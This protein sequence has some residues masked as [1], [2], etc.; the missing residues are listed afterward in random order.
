M[1]SRHFGVTR[2]VLIKY[3][4]SCRASFKYVREKTVTCHGTMS[5][6]KDRM[7]SSVGQSTDPIRIPT[8]E[9]I[10]DHE[11]RTNTLTCFSSMACTNSS[12]M[13]CFCQSGPDQNPTDSSTIT[14]LPGA[15]FSDIHAS[16]SALWRS[17][18]EGLFGFTTQC[19]AASAGLSVS[20]RPLFQHARGY[21]EYCTV[22]T[23]KYG[24]PGAA[25][26]RR[27]M[28]S[29]APLPNTSRSLAGAIP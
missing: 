10:F 11:W 9:K 5:A 19:K 14:Q 26:T 23:G 24:P 22:G 29:L 4:S 21:A 15:A 17:S 27:S 6:S 7:E 12:V 3:S 13:P 28:S 2:H 25:L 1:C 16:S 8:Q 20:S 18:P